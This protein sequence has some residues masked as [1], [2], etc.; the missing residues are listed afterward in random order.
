M[1]LIQNHFYVDGIIERPLRKNNTLVDN[2][3][4]IPRTVI[5]YQNT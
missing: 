3:L 1:A 2:I 4:L 5:E